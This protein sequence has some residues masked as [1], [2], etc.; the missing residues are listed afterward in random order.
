MLSL[1]TLDAMQAALA[2]P[3][4]NTLYQIIADRVADAVA[5]GCEHLTHIVVV[6]PGDGE[7][8]FLREAAF[9][10]FRNPL[11]DTRYGDPGFEPHWNFARRYE[12][13]Y[14]W[15]ICI[16]NGGFAF[17]VLC[18]DSYDIDPTLLAMLREF[19]G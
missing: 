11:S 7:G 1:P 16:G 13:I 4:D 17:I 5:C 14:E 6:E 3:M 18:P 15:L 19:V 2:G 9:S 10:P 8:D 12:N